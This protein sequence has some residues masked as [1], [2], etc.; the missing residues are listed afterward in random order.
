MTPVGGAAE[1]LRDSALSLSR[2]HAFARS[3][4]N[5]G[6]LSTPALLA[7]S[8]LSTAD[9]PECADFSGPM[10]PGAAAVDAPFGKG[11]WLD[12]LDGGFEL[13]HFTD[14]GGTGPERC[15][16]LPVHCAR[17]EGQLASRYDGRPGTTWLFRPDQHVAARWRSLDPALVGAAL[18]R[19]RGRP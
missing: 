8:P 15:A 2:T 7:G 16:G 10:R 19:A 3:F 5:S 14:E 9:E 6:R 1:A 4:V 17:S 18:D 13:L 12:R 11:W